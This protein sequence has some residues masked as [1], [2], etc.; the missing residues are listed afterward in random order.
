MKQDISL[1]VSESIAG[2]WQ[3]NEDAKFIREFKADG[4]AADWYDKK[5]VSEGTWKAYTS[6]SG[7][8]TAFP[9][10]RDTVYIQMVMQGTQGEALNFKL[11]K[12]TPEVL[13]LIYME[14]GGGLGF[15]RV[16]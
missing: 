10:E 16:R 5:I 13:E 4:T 3:S 6:E 15:K 12:L 11:V 9:Q 14:R 1:I 2:T 8:E 7:V